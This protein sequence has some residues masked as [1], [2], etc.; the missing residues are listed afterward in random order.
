MKLY[1]FTNSDVFSKLR[2]NGRLDENTRK[3]LDKPSFTVC[4]A[5]TGENIGN[6]VDIST[7]GIMIVSEKPV[8]E[9]DVYQLRMEFLH[10]ILFNARCAWARDIGSGN[11]ISGLEFSMIEP[12]DIETI[13]E[14]VNKFLAGE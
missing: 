8:T 2:N 4:D 13:E 12:K 5:V 14:A 9:N 3:L 11:Y 7:T 10:D 1:S 6:L